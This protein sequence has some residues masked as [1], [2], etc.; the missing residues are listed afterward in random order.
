M[1]GTAALV[2]LTSPAGS[3]ERQAIIELNRAVADVEV[4]RA[5]VAQGNTLVEEL[6]DDH[7]TFKTVVDELKLDY[8]AL[9]ADVTAIRAE[10]VKLVTDMASRI[11][12]FNTLTTKLN[13]DIGVTDTNYAA[14]A[15]A[16]A[17]N[18]SAIT[19]TAIAAST[20]AT[21]TATK[22][23]SA[24]VNTAGDLLASQVKDIAGTVVAT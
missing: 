9:L 15:A 20:P 8:T 5:V 11:S 14:A 4:V 13:A 22:P 10:V 1:A 2:R 6:H 24:N 19:G 16:T 17:A 12:D 23:T 21:L 7:A 3:A 18:P